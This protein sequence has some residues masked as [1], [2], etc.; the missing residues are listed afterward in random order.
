MYNPLVQISKEMVQ[1][2]IKESSPDL[3]AFIIEKKNKTRI[4]V[5]VKARLYELLEI[6]YF[7]IPSERKKGFCTEAVKIFV[8]FLF[9]S[10]QIVRIQAVTN[11]KNLGSQKVLEKAGFIKEGIVRKM[12][13]NRGDWRDCILFSILREEWKEPKI[14]KI[15]L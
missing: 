11:E 4:G 7:L 15:Q 13:F 10:K 12:M 9:L 8:D 5:I 3:Q 2:I 14:L 1:R 6:G